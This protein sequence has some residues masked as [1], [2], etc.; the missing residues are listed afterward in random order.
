MACG[1]PFETPQGEVD[2]EAIDGLQLVDRTARMPKAPSSD[3]RNQ[4]A[5]ARDERRP[6]L[7]VESVLRFYSRYGWEIVT[8][9]LRF[10]RLLVR[11][12]WLAR[13]LERDPE[14]ENYRD[15]SSPSGLSEDVLNLEL[16][17]PRVST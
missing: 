8:K 4:D 12:R 17:A 7:P 3:H 16:L 10:L 5:A 14:A 9:H 11:L 2:P 13:R 1:D 6:D 15:D